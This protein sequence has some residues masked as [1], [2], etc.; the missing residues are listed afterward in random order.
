MAQDELTLNI[1][2]D[3][4]ASGEALFKSLGMD[5]SSAVNVFV[6]EAVTQG[7]IPFDVDDSDTDYEP[8]APIDLEKLR[9]DYKAGRVKSIPLEVV[10]REAYALHD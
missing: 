2:S 5:F 6:R 9:A 7:K 8:E 4:R 3:L 10:R 1:D